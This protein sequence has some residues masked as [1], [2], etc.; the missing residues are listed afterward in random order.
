MNFT[1]IILSVLALIL[2]ALIVF[3]QYFFRNNI[4]RDQWGMAVLRFMAIFA[5]FLLLIN[6]IVEKRTRELEKP[7]L[8][9]AIDNSAS[10]NRPAIDDQLKKFKRALDEDDELKN[11]FEVSTFLFG[12][13]LT[14]DSL[15][16]FEEVQT[17]IYSAIKDLEALNE[18]G[19][20]SILMV[21]DGRQTYGQN[22]AYLNAKN[23]IF[24]IVTGDTLDVIDLSIDR[25]NTNAYA[26][27]D[28]NFPVEIFVNTN[29][30]TAL[31]SKLIVEKKGKEVFSKII[32]FD[33]DKST[34]IVTMLLPADTVGMQ[35]YS[36]RVE[37][38]Q[39]E[40]VLGNNLRNFGVEIL[41]EQ[42]NIA[43][44]YGLLHPDVGMIKRSIESNRQRKASL[45]RIEDIQ[46]RKDEFDLFILYQPNEDFNDMW[47]YV[48]EKESNYMLITGTQTNWRLIDEFQKEFRKERTDLVENLFPDFERD[49][50]AFYTEDI[51]FSLFPP[52]RGKI[53]EIVLGKNN[54]VLLT[55]RI[56]DI[57]SE[58]PLLIVS[59]Q[60]DQKSISL[61][62]E[63]IWKWRAES[64]SI[65]GSFTEF[66][67][68]FNSLIQYLQLSDRN[69]DMELSYGPV[70]HAKQPV[71]IQAKKYDSNLN[72]DLNSNLVLQFEGSDEIYPF[73][74]K[75]R[76]YEVKISSLSP[77]TY[78][79]N[80]T[81]T[82]SEE[83]RRGSFIVDRFSL[84]EENINPNVQDLKLLADQSGGTIYFIDQFENVK[85][86]L[87]N[88]DKFR[89]LE[90]VQIKRVSLID[91][92]WLLGLIVLS[93]SLEWFLRKY[94]G[95]I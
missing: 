26:T 70:Y 74:I 81:D 93:L 1:S 15:W 86:E 77:G 59:D 3:Y 95:L 36:A 32:A 90:K 43:I 51:G 9:L 72:L 54:Q 76:S 73:Y 52:L 10:M 4:T 83:I 66:D 8:F 61:L 44:V 28:N 58:N 5:A 27:L 49:F 23:P 34:E 13:R 87:M 68:F 7:K 53:G 89:S 65:H 45:L 33:L 67:N 62:G 55:Q 19:I 35:L 84:E 22:Y 16:N 25:V 92:R 48:N 30:S 85:T 57:Q 18:G 2:S 40:K 80:V 56:N 60:G 17:N 78:N 75:N 29:K 71:L 50:N 88:N 94:R 24:P 31:K 42:T 11:R 91:W 39:N 20:S 79:F 21:T 46:N 14:K 64:F 6:P 37:P 41:D 82:E 38:V 47:T 63:N 12:E 69:K